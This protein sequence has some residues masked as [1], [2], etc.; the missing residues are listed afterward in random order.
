M[1]LALQMVTFL[2]WTEHVNFLPIPFF[3]PF[4]EMFCQ[5]R[6]GLYASSKEATPALYWQEKA[7]KE[8]LTPKMGA[9]CKEVQYCVSSLPL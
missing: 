6:A 2:I 4:K 8:P 5:E 7:D 1:T 9:K 3:P